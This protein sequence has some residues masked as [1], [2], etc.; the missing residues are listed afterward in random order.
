[1]IQI[2]HTLIL[3]HYQKDESTLFDGLENVTTAGLFFQRSTV[4]D[5]ARTAST[6]PVLMSWIAFCN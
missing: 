5:D 3:C 6:P 2:G 4:L 1:M